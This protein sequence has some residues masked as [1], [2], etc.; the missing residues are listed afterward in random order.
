MKVI[1]S[2]NSVCQFVCPCTV[3]M[4]TERG[5]HS[6]IHLRPGACVG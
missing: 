5:R 3:C 1:E 6:K 4:H 2:D